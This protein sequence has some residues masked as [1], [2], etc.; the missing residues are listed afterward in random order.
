M[1]QAAKILDFKNVG[2]TKL[3]AFLRRKNIL[4]EN[5][6]PFQKYINT[7]HFKMVI[8]D[9]YNG[10]GTVIVCPTVPLVSLKGINFIKKLFEKNGG[11]D[12]GN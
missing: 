9:I 5:N 1:Q 3:M 12:E 7:R 2:R 6:E 11:I 8:K 10:H 4:M